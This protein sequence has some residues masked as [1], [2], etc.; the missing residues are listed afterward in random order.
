ME[1]AH[2]RHCGTQ[3]QEAALCADAWLA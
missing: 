3:Q 2:R 1:R